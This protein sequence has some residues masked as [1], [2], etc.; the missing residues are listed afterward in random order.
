MDQKNCTQVVESLR[1][2]IPPQRGVDLYSVGNEK[3]I[4]G[5]KRFHLS[6]IGEGGLI[7]FISGSWGAGKTHFFRLLRE[8]AF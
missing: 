1:K 8:V 6:A 2:G 4:L 7:R 3:L 5:I